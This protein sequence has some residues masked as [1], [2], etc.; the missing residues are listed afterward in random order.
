MSQLLHTPGTFPGH[1]LFESARDG[2]RPA[3]LVF[4]LVGIGNLSP[5]WAQQYQRQT[6]TGWDFTQAADSLG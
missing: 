2:W 3:V 5:V 1:S 4:L 6:L